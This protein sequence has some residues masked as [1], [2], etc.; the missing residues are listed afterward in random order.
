[1]ATH[2]SILTWESPWMVGYNP[3]GGKR[4]KYDLGTKQQHHDRTYY[5]LKFKKKKRKKKCIY[6]SLCKLL[7]SHLFPTM[8]SHALCLLN[9][10]IIFLFFFFSLWVFLLTC[11]QFTNP[12][13]YS[14]LLLNPTIMFLI[15]STAL[16]DSKSFHLTFTQLK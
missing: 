1:M 15:S 14:N 12:L 11:L 6:E 16:F 3:W 4:V 13:F 10:S 8:V 7:F 5:R 2:S 9:S